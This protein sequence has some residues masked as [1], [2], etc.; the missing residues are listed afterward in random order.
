[1]IK[2]TSLKAYLEKNNIRPSALAKRCQI[3]E[4]YL[5]RLLNGQ[6]P[7]PR[8]PVLVRLAATLGLP[9]HVVQELLRTSD[10]SFIS[11]N[12]PEVFSEQTTQEQFYNYLQQIMDIMEQSD[13]AKISYLNDIICKTIPNSIPL[14]SNYL[15]WYEAKKLNY[16]NKFEY[17]I[18]LFLEASKFTPRYQIEKRFKAKIL[19]GLGAA[20]M[21][22]G[23]YSQ[24]MKSFRQSLFLWPEGYQAARVYMN[25]GTLYR[26]LTKYELSVG[27]YERAYEFGTT[28]TKLYAIVGLIQVFLDEKDYKS[29]RKYVLKGYAQ[30]ESFDF[31]RGKSELYC[32]IAE[33]YLATNKLY[34]S[35]IFFRKAILF[36]NIS[37]NLRAKHWAEVELALVFLRKGLVKEFNA[38][39]K[40]LE[41][42]LSGPEDILLI[43]KHLN[44]MG[45]HHLDL[46]DYSHVILI[47]GKAYR[48]LITLSPLPLIEFK[49]SCELLYEAYSASKKHE[50]AS[51]YLNEIKRI[52]QIKRQ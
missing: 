27:A 36:A 43:V 35:E 2:G 47:V 48:L 17:A 41:S 13:F 51:F 3:D 9:V 38:I 8:F 14:K 21:V 52:K 44:A 18:P 45:R 29:A 34:Y 33:Y 20:Y 40:K 25:I 50:I 32:N 23:N 4:G 12:I 6:R 39:I 31:P 16:Q 22:R 19:K 30:V 10:D 24:S 37:G 11:E 42:E 15:F 26:R 28:V 5:S 1:M 46:C 7:N 49:E